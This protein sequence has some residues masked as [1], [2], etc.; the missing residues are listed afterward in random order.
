MQSTRTRDDRTSDSTCEAPRPVGGPERGG[1]G[2]V[3]TTQYLG[4]KYVYI[5]DLDVECRVQSAEL[6]SSNVVR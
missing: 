5:V 4:V 6:R 1:E 3:S 2:R